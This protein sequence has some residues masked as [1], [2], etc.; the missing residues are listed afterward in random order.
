M[1]SCVLEEAGGQHVRVTRRANHP[2]DIRGYM[3]YNSSNL[4]NPSN[5]RNA[6]LR[7]R[8][9][10]GGRGRATRHATLSN[11]SNAAVAV[12]SCVTAIAGRGREEPH[13]MQR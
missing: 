7:D 11:I 2:T 10:G 8:N 3:K 9:R 12:C 1:Q 4:S 5:L 13:Y 6:E